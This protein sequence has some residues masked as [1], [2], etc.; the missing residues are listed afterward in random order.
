MLRVKMS[1]LNYQ[2]QANNHLDYAQH[3][4]DWEVETFNAPFHFYSVHIASNGKLN[5]VFSVDDIAEKFL[6]GGGGIVREKLTIPGVASLI[7][8][9]DAAG[10]VFSFIEEDQ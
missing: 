2:Y 9:V 10:H 3:T 8:C 5:K 4:S 7:S 1:G 6:A